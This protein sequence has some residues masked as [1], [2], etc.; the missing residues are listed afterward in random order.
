MD[1]TFC[2]V[3]LLRSASTVT[4]PEKLL[5]QIP[6]MQIYV[7]PAQILRGPWGEERVQLLQTVYG[8][9]R[10][11]YYWLRS[12][13]VAERTHFAWPVID[14]AVCLQGVHRAIRGNHQAPFFCLLDLL[15]LVHGSSHGRL[16][17]PG[18]LYRTAVIHHPEDPTFLWRLIQTS[19]ASLP[20]DEEVRRW[21]V[22]ARDRG[23]PTGFCVL[24]IM[25]LND[26][27]KRTSS[28]FCRRV[29]DRIVEKVTRLVGRVGRRGAGLNEGG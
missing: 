14:R 9:I 18:H 3:S 10:R 29:L 6:V 7:L 23:D 8:E 17:L 4:V 20:N 2:R 24:E 15:E 1:R 16:A 5:F 22:A 27:R 11:L 25:E 13:S 19:A 26:L 12:R 21:A 28:A